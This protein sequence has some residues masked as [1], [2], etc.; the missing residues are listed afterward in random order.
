MFDARKIKAELADYLGVW[1]ADFDVEGIMDELKEI[2]PDIETIDDVDY[3]FFVDL[4]KRHDVSGL[5]G[6][7]G[8]AGRRNRARKVAPLPPTF[9]DGGDGYVA[10]SG[11]A[12]TWDDFLQI[13]RGNQ[14]LANVVHDICDGR[15][16]E[17][18][19]DEMLREGDVVEVG[20]IA[21]AMADGEGDAIEDV[22]TLL[23]EAWEE[24]SD[25][26]IDDDELLGADWR[27]F[28]AGAERLEVWREFDELYSNGVRA[29]MFPDARPE[30]TPG[31]GASD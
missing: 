24:F 29:L 20:R 23:D 3:D 4:I 30:G 12:Y 18:V 14:R 16:P 5:E 6:R 15:H 11:E 13:A 7:G 1:A 10:D 21:Y 27:G 22:D 25:V 9:D 17:T 8:K 19:L 28:R 26:P 2:H 31:R